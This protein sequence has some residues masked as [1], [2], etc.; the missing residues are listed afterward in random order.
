MPSFLV[1]STRAALTSSACA[2][3]SSA[4]GPAISTSGRSLPSV[5]SP[6]ATWRGCI[7]KNPP[8]LAPSPLS[9]RRRPGPM[10]A[11]A[12][13]V[14]RWIP[15]FAGMTIYSTSGEPRSVPKLNKP[16]LVDCGFDEGCEQRVRLERLRLQLGMELHADEPGVV[17]KLDD[18]RQQP[19][20]RH[21]R[22]PQTR[23]FEAVAI[24][25]VDLIAMAVPLA[26]PAGGVDLSD[27][28][29]RVEHRFIG[30]EPHRAAEIAIH[31]ALL[32]HVAAHPLGHQ[33]NHRMLALAE[34]GR[35]GAGQPGQMPRRLDHRHLHAETDAEIRHVAFARETR[36]LD[37]ALR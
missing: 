20:G 7:S 28:A 1:I 33:P 16:R 35:A 14:D 8:V 5:M 18:L 31:V 3:L 17:G 12:R 11:G 25:D 13:A 21:A 6:M 4:H 2:R 37:L 32:Y 9:S 19:V 24:G 23:L 29:F 22:E 27:A 36:R 10:A 30:A 15:A 26:D 34:L